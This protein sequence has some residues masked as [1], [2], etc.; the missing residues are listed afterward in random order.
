MGKAHIGCE[1]QKLCRFKAK[2]L[3]ASNVTLYIH[4]IMEIFC[5]DYIKR[6]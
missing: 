6:E 3:N 5:I 2:W 4:C 1:H